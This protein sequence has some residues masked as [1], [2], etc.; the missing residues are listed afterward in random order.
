MG[1]LERLRYLLDIQRIPATVDPI[2]DMLI[3][4][5]RHS[6]EVSPAMPP[7]LI[8]VLV[9]HCGVQLPASDG[10]HRARVLAYWQQHQ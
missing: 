3:I 1:L 10:V 7:T 8:A 6:A 9:S 5:G 4:I 2:V